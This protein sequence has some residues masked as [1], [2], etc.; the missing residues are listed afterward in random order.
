M[1]ESG[2]LM[3]S[4]ALAL[5]GTLALAVPV[6]AQQGPGG[7]PQGPGNQW[8]TGGG[9]GPGGGGAYCPATPG[10][11]YCPRTSSDNSQGLQKRQRMRARSRAT[12]ANQPTP[13][14][15]PP[16]ENQ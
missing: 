4:L 6:F 3:T 2:W 1:K 8:C 7:G 12:Q 11:Q 5:A 15:T 14:A 16:A 10:N 13:Q 9:Q